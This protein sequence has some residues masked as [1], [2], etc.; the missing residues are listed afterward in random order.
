M[1]MSNDGIEGLG[2]PPA[3]P[4]CFVQPE[5]PVRNSAFVP[6]AKGPDAH[7]SVW[8]IGL[9]GAL[10]IGVTVWAVVHGVASRSED[11]L[12]HPT[13]VNAS[14]AIDPPQ[15]SQPI[16]VMPYAKP[17][18]LS[19]N[20]LVVVSGPQS[21]GG[22]SF[23]AID[24][25]EDQTIWTVA[26]KD[27]EM[28]GVMYHY[29]GDGTGFAFSSSSELTVIDPKTGDTTSDIP[30]DY[31]DLYWAGN[32]M[33]LINARLSDTLCA[34]TMLDPGTC[35]WQA[36]INSRLSKISFLQYG[37]DTSQ[38]VFG[39]GRWVNT[40][41]G[42]LDAS[43]G[44]PASFGSRSSI[45]TYFSGESPNRIFKVTGSD[46]GTTISYQ[47]WDVTKDTAASSAV[48]ANQAKADPASDVYLAVFEDDKLATISAYDWQS[49]KRRW[50]KT[51]YRGDADDPIQF[52]NG[53]YVGPLVSAKHPLG[54]ITAVNASTGKQVWQAPDYDFYP[55]IS[56]HLLLVQD[57]TYLTAYDMTNS[58][59]AVWAVPLPYDD[60]TVYSMADHV[61]CIG[62]N[63]LMWVLM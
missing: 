17:I 41:D 46:D 26:S 43:T 31:R 48:N 28:A 10:V 24:L 13:G 11:Q 30:I 4:V 6:A 19:T 7:R 52:G 37:I 50:Q 22:W 25:N 57:S 14:M 55:K 12:P 8:L 18:D 51:I 5:S 15:W 56:G 47:P 54:I 20:D 60:V 1:A 40:L 29:G 35:L 61:F 9:I 59:A 21:N 39:G 32:G 42:V 63:A 53:F 27:K 62:S 36:R 3:E 2:T 49:G 45:D 34:A 16:T 23:V 33:L 38:Y 44:Q 58:F